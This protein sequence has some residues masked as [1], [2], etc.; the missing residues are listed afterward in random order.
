MMSMLLTWNQ[1][2]G[3]TDR[4]R[5]IEAGAD[6]LAAAF[7]LSADMTLAN[8]A[9]LPGTILSGTISTPTSAPKSATTTAR[10]PSFASLISRSNR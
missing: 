3:A 8:R 7:G 6:H 2:I 4:G 10:S 9:A 1:W 5:A